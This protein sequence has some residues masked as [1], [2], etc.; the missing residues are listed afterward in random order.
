MSPYAVPSGLLPQRPF[1]ICCELFSSVNVSFLPPQTPVY[2]LGSVR[3]ILNSKLS[4][5]KRLKRS[6]NCIWSL[7]IEPLGSTQARSSNPEEFTTRVSPSQCAVEYPYHR[8]LGL[9]GSFR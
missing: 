3:V 8:G 6:S 2:A 4:W 9:V 1:W 5:S 7:W